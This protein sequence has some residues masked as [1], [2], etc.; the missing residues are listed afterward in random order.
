[1][2]AL[3]AVRAQNFFVLTGFCVLGTT[4]IG[5]TS[6]GTAAESTAAWG[7]GPEGTSA[8]NPARVSKSKKTINEVARVIKSWAFSPGLAVLPIWGDSRRKPHDSRG[9]CSNYFRPIQ[10]TVLWGNGGAVTLH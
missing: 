1:M 2:A 5:C 3:T 9:A 4:T 10:V 8:A 6:G 7:W